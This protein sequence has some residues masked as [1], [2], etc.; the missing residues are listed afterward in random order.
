[1]NNGTAES[2]QLIKVGVF[3]GR[4]FQ[5]G[6]T[7]KG[8]DLTGFKLL[9]Y[10]L[11]PWFCLEKNHASPNLGQNFWDQFW[12]SEVLFDFLAKSNQIAP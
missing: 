8:L 11:V 9:E 10:L 3:K 2:P 5:D 1:M 7:L 4:V 12:H 6:V